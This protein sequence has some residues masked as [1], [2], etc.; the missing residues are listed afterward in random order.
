M[1]FLFLE[2]WPSSR[3][4]EWTSIKK[5]SKKESKDNIKLEYNFKSS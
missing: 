3:Q 5:E 4:I 2:H 1:E